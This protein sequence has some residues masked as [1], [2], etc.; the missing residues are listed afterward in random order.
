MKAM[1][2]EEKLKRKKTITLIIVYVAI[3]LFAFIVYYLT[4]PPINP[5]SEVFWVFLAFLVIIYLAPVGFTVTRGI[6]EPRTKAQK[7]AAFFRSGAKIADFYVKPK[8]YCCSRL[9]R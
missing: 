8:K 5:Q 2:E 4:L 3:T 9:F 7:K 6:I 1:T